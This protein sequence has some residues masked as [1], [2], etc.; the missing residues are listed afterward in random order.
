[1]G[2]QVAM[3][4]T[5]GSTAQMEEGQVAVAVTQGSTAQMEEGQAGRIPDTDAAPAVVAAGSTDV[6]TIQVPNV[7]HFAKMLGYRTCLVVLALV[8]VATTITSAVMSAEKFKLPSP[9]SVTV[10]VHS[11]APKD[12]NEQNRMLSLWVLVF[13]VGPAIGMFGAKRLSRCAIASYFICCIGKIGFVA[14]FTVRFRLLFDGLIC[15]LQIW[16]AKVIASFWFSLGKI[17]REDRVAALTSKTIAVPKF[18]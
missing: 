9:S 13:L 10:L 11:E 4:V 14:F 1:M 17:S 3:A 6:E 18:W 16:I 2:G 15:L 12:P 8:D 7:S 5:Q